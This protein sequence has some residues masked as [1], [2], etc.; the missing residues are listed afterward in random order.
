[1]GRKKV[2]EGIVEN[3]FFIDVFDC[4]IVSVMGDT[5]EQVW[6]HLEDTWGYVE[7]DGMDFKGYTDIV[8]GMESTMGIFTL[9]VREYISPGIIS[10]ESYHAVSFLTTHLM[11]KDEETSAYLLDWVVDKQ[12]IFYQPELITWYNKNK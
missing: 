8:P 12:H 4:Q 7:A 9:F 3:V 5:S 6:E 1:V 10:H 11:I 2:I